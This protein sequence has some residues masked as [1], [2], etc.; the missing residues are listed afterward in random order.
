MESEGIRRNQKESEGIRRI[1]RRIIRR[2]QKE[3]EGIRWNQM[4]SDG[5]RRILHDDTD[6]QSK[7]LPVNRTSQKQKES[8]GFCP[9]FNLAHHSYYF[10]TEGIR[11]IQNAPPGQKHMG[12]KPD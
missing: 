3:S 12:P 9:R 4:E 7:I 6:G 5:I 11:R 10:K 1:I 8:E 2:N